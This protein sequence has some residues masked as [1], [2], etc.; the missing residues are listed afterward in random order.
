VA[1][2]NWRRAS[3]NCLPCVI[4]QLKQNGCQCC[5][6]E[7]GKKLPLRSIP[8]A[9]F[10]DGEF[11]AMLRWARDAYLL[12][13]NTSFVKCSTTHCPEIQRNPPVVAGGLKQFTCRTCKKTQPVGGSA[14]DG[15]DA[16]K[17]NAELPT[18]VR[19]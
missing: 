10:G 4:L 16:E 2:A 19:N 9:D 6:F 7:C 17:L 15:A 1:T 18:A 12:K 5:A 3:R 8:I 13:N 14:T 11:V